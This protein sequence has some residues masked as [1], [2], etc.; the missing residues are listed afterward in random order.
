MFLAEVVAVISAVSEPAVVGHHLPSFML[1]S[2][3]S[4]ITRGLFT[5][6]HHT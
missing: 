3:I 5:L 1:T 4:R 2:P 6:R